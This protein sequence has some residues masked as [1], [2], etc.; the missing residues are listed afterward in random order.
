MIM[1]EIATIGFIFVAHDKASNR[2]K[3][4][5]TRISIRTYSF[6]VIWLISALIMLC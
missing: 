3:Y 5:I 4:K 1:A 6:Y 2:N